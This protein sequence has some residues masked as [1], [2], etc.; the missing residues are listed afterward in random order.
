[1]SKSLYDVLQC[2]RCGSEECYTYNIDDIEFEHTGE[3]HYYVDCHCKECDNGF[4]LYMQF[5]YNVT[6]ATTGI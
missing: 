3:G 6:S 2:P 1:M 4:R 5:T